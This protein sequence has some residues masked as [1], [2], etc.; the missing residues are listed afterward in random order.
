VGDDFA[1]TPQTVHQRTTDLTGN[2]G[3]KNTHQTAP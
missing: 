3:H 1:H 2:S